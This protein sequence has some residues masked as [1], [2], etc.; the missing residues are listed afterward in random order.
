M[1]HDDDTVIDRR[2]PFAAVSAASS[3]V[4][5]AAASSV[6]LGRYEVGPR[7]G[8]GGFGEVLEA[9]DRV[10]DKQVAIKWLPALDPAQLADARSEVTALRRARLPGVV[11][12]LDDGLADGR[13][14][15]VMEHITGPEFPGE[16]IPMPWSRLRPKIIRLLEILAGVHQAG[17][18]HRDLKPA[19]VR[20][21]PEG[22]PIL[23]DF[24]LAQPPQGDSEDRAGTPGYIAPEVLFGR[25]GA[26]A[27]SDL[28]ALG[29][30]IFEALRGEKPG[31]YGWDHA[32]MPDEAAE[33]LAMLLAQDPDHRAPSAMAV[34]AE[35]DDVAVVPDLPAEPATELQL[36]AAFAGP[37]PFVHFCSRGAA[38]LWARTGGRG[39]ARELT[40]WQRAGLAEWSDAGIEVTTVSLDRIEDGMR[41]GTR[42]V[43]IED[44]LTP[45]AQHLLHWIRFAWPT[46][47]SAVRAACGFSDGRH[48]AAA[49]ELMATQLAWPH[50]GGMGARPVV[51]GTPAWDAID[52]A[53][54]RLKL[55]GHLGA[56]DP[57]RLV[58][59]AA[60]GGAPDRILDAAEG[61]IEAELSRGAYPE[62]RRII[63]LALTVGRGSFEAEHTWLRW[64]AAWAIYVQ[65]PQGYDWALY[66]I[67]RASGRTDAIE[68][69]EFLIRAARADQAR[70]HQRSNDL[71]AMCRPFEDEALEIGRQSVALGVAQAG[72]AEA[73]F[74]EALVTWASTPSRAARLASWRGNLLYRQ[75]AFVEA[76]RAH[77]RAAKN[78][79]TRTGRLRALL[80]A[81]SAML[82]GGRLGDAE[83]IAVR[84]DLVA[85][86]LR[87]PAEEAWSRLLIRAA[88]YRDG[89]VVKVDVQWTMAAA[90]ISPYWRGMLALTESAIAWRLFDPAVEH[91]AQ[92]AIECFGLCRLEPHLLLAQAVLANWRQDLVDDVWITAAI[93]CP[94][95]AIGAQ[96]LGLLGRFDEARKL[97]AH[98]NANHW[99]R[100]LE[101]LSFQEAVGQQVGLRATRKG[102]P[103]VTSSKRS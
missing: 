82:D 7:I 5:S 46:V 55:A 47:G 84:A 94:M 37:E 48:A 68:Q 6:V 27:R 74:L 41:L 96:I 10:L 65:S 52:Q 80:G 61:Q 69:L 33:M 23:L 4:L 54:A 86:E 20:L 99:G 1:T 66:Q 12:L 32:G 42:D 9:R 91:L 77:L 103:W 29:V 35:F 57:Q 21:T 43:A 11:P 95:P 2:S 87:L 18:V 67:G 16:T 73:E 19:N 14:V 45:D 79:L 38:L 62:A 25:S 22:Q 81:G 53:R 58:N 101:V 78:R 98:R 34:L 59:L 36:H 24:G 71:L 17:L 15:L 64:V 8:R 50:A 26:D 102:H 13:F 3:S 89:C 76:A 51:D 39:L 93:E 85:R 92:A 28:Y 100:R 31:Y 30:M 72:G 90:W 83:R 56:D 70:E 44:A 40:S 75:E 88:Q 97:A 49:S 60:G 63:E